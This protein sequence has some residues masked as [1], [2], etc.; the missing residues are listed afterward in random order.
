MV[1]SGRGKGGGGAGMCGE[2]STV[3]WGAA[4][5]RPGVTERAGILRKPFASRKPYNM[6]RVPVF[7]NPNLYFKPDIQP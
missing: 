1:W 5:G 7:I 2:G 4:G 6:G 3:G